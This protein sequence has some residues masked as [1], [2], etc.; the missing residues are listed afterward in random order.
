MTASE[1]YVETALSTA[2]RAASAQGDRIEAAAR[3]A[4]DAIRKGGFVFAFGT[5][6]SHMLAEEIF[7]R[8]GGLANI[9]PLLKG[10]LMLHE[11]ASTSSLYERTPGIGTTVIENSGIQ[12]GDVDETL[13]RFTKTLE[14][15]ANMG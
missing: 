3:L 2:Q 7:Y 10:F 1:R 5:G 12:S 11:S 6:H 4:A 15:F 9:A 8:A 14:R 13:A